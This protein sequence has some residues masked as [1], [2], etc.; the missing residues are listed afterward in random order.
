[1]IY[2][3]EDDCQVRK[4]KVTEKKKYHGKLENKVYG[5]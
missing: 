3:Q 5:A 1:M 4:K 2:K